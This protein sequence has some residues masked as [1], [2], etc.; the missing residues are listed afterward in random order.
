MRLLKQK[1]LSLSL[2]C[3]AVLILTGCYDVNGELSVRREIIDVGKTN[4]GD[5]VSAS[6]TFKNNTS[7]ELAISFLP[8]CD[9]TTINI[10]NMKLE[11]SGFGLLEVKV[12]VEQPG[13][14]IKYVFVQP[15]G[16]EDFMTVAVK[17]RT[18]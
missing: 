15:A 11:P 13:D 16:S 9:C 5:S 18:K 6:F 1:K 14:F 7:K 2:L 4:V 3:A 17:G 12:A 10:D 8:E